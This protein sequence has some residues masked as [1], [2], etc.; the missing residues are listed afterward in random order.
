MLKK[1]L[2]AKIVNIIEQK[3]NYEKLFELRFRS[4]RKVSVNYDG[5]FYY[6]CEK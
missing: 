4:R 1:I 6:L 2:P 5:K 3:L